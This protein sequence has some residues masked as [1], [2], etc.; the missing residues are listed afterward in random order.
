M[1]QGR[2]SGYDVQRRNQ[3]CIY[4]VLVGSGVRVSVG[5]GVPVPEGLGVFVLVGSMVGVRLGVSKAASSFS[6][7]CRI[8]EVMS[9]AGIESKV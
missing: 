4:G 2:D 6:A 9:E 3:L 7:S 8:S 5:I 1:N